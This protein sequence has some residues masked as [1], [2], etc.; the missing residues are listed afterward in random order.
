MDQKKLP[1]SISV[2]IAA[3]NAELV[4]GRAV[5][6]VLAQTLA[7]D[8]ILVVDDGST[9]RTRQVIEQFGD[10]VRYIYQGNAGASAARNTAIEAASGR[11]IAFLDADD[12]WLPDRLRLQVQL[13]E[14]HPDLKWV[15]GNF[16]RCFCGRGHR[17]EIDLSALQRRRTETILQDGEIFEGYFTAHQVGAMGCTDTMLIRRDLLVE[18]GLF[19]SGQKRMNDLDLWLRLA[20]RRPLIGY[21][22]EPLAVYHMGVPGSILKAHRQADHI[23]QFLQRHFKLA[24]AAGMS[25]EFRPFAAQIL[26][27]WLGQRMQDGDGRQIRYL[28]R[29]YKDLF[30]RSSRAKRYLLSWC[31]GLGTF[32]NR[33]KA[34]LKKYIQEKKAGV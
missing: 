13:L 15:T 14:R 12:Q 3:Y 28:L 27:W 24:E 2:V 21:V 9:D 20:Y 31:P 8:E 1:D 4:V 19:F 26:G 32:Y 23:E 6:S 7:P 16:Y 17:Q 11:W 5:E 34:Q 10:K 30:S 29:K 25:E 33:K 18:A 22:F